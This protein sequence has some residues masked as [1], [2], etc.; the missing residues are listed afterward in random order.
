MALNRAI[1]VGKIRGAK[2]GLDAVAAIQ[3]LD[4]LESYYLL[5]AVL[6]EFES[7]LNNPKIAGKHFRR[8]LELA[9]IKSE[10]A[11]LSKRL[12]ACETV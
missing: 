9:E 7:Q 1:V 12:G 2:S 6:G 10:R 5:Y 3:N 8:S 4:K 11:F